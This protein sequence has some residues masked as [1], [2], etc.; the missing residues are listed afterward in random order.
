MTT[1]V[2]EDETMTGIVVFAMSI[3]LLDMLKYSYD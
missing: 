2:N 1:T 3:I